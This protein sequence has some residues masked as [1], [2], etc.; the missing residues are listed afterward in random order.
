MT[1]RCE[2]CGANNHAQNGSCLNCGASLSPHRQHQTP[3]APKPAVQVQNSPEAAGLVALEELT[4]VVEAVDPVGPVDHQSI[5]STPSV[6]YL[7]QEES[8]ASHAGRYFFLIA[9]CAAVAIA[10]WHWRD[11]QSMAL[12][13]RT[14][15]QANAVS[16]PASA[17]VP[18]TPAPSL[19]S[20]APAPVEPTTQSASAEETPAPKPAPETENTS[21]EPAPP[22]SSKARIRRATTRTASTDT[23]E[24][25]GE[26]YL[27]GDGVPQNCDVA[28]KD[29]TRAAKHSAKAQTDLAAMYATGHCALR[30]LP[31][32][33]HWFA[34]AEHQAPHGDRKIAEDMRVLWNQMT[35]EERRLA[36]R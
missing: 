11:V 10:G 23:S 20:S 35:P 17:P 29:L 14:S 16:T 32:A 2:Q 7:Y 3:A 15:V 30:D 13:L 34:R 1:I 4:P 22:R 18:T 24:L 21:Q 8:S 26:K 19:Q 12:R 33:Y 9:V 27:Y 31:L 6:R 25:E 36:V 5:N 28:R